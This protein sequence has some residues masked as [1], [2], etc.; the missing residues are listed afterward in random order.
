MVNLSLSF[1]EGHKARQHFTRLVQHAHQALRQQEMMKTKVPVIKKAVIPLQVKA[2][3]LETF[4]IRQTALQ[5]AVT[6]LQFR[7]AEISSFSEA[8]SSLR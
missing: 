6:C 5:F 4:S 7:V 3:I 1:K 2:L 8:F